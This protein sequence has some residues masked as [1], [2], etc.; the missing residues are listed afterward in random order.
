MRD[1]ELTKK[2]VKVAAT[3]TLPVFVGDRTH[4]PGELGFELDGYIFPDFG[5]TNRIDFNDLFFDPDGDKIEVVGITR[6]GQPLATGPHDSNR[7]H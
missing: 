4:S 7:R 6:S 1:R 5:T 3:N 2:T